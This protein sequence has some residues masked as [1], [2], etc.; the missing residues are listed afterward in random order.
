MAVRS[1]PHRPS[2]I[3]PS[4]YEYVGVFYQGA[5]DEEHIAYAREIDELE[6][7]AGFEFS[8]IPFYADGNFA[9]KHSC[10]HCGARFA[11]G[12]VYRYKVSGEFIAIGHICASGLDL[13]LDVASRARRAAERSAKAAKS[14]NA[15]AAFR[16]EVLA[17]HDGLAEALDADHYI[18]EDIARRF[19]G[20][21]PSLSEKQIALVFKLAAEAKVRAAEREA[22]EAASIPV[23]EGNGIEI[24]G[25]VL[26]VKWRDDAF[27]GSLKM[28]VLDDRL[29]KVWGSVPAAIKHVIL[30]DG[31]WRGL[32][33]GDRVAFVA[34][35]ERSND[36]ESFGFFK[37][38]RRASILSNDDQEVA[39]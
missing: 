1:D 9:Q 8:E 5:S 18:V 14:R 10:D 33:R 7:N 38:P 22:F 16:A 26:S 24:S 29:F 25:E 37:R 19:Y 39:A 17:A 31:E 2:V 36:D 12:V 32:E 3:D 11:H 4:A 13:A 30:G 27:G 35:V 21:K 28:L 6:A 15:N 34:N 23:I 20:S